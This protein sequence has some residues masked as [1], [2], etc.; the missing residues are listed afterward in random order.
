VAREDA[1][2]ARLHVRI[3]QS[4]LPSARLADIV[5]ATAQPALARLENHVAQARRH[6]SAH[7]AGALVPLRALLQAVAPDLA[8]LE[9]LAS[10]PGTAHLYGDQVRLVADTVL[11]GLVACQRVTGDDLGCLPLLFH[12]L[13]I[14]SAPELAQRTAQAF[15]VMLENALVAARISAGEPIP[16]DHVLTLR[17]ITRSISAGLGSLGL[18]NAATV[19]TQA[20]LAGWLEKLAE[21]ALVLS[22]SN[23]GWALHTLGHAL[24]LPIDAANREAL[25]RIQAEWLF[26]APAPSLQPFV[27]IAGLNNLRID[28]SGVTLNNKLLRTAD[29][30]GIRHQMAGFSGE[31]PQTIGWCS[32]DEG[33]E[34]DEAWFAALKGMMNPATAARNILAALHAFL[35]P[36]LLAR[37]IQAVR[38]GGVITMGESRLSAEGLALTEGGRLLPFAR[39][40]LAYA[41]ERVSISSADHPSLTVD[42]DPLLN[43][44]V[45]LLPHFIAAFTPRLP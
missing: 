27:L 35:V 33:F 36:S 23:L 38:G 32:S 24:D 4:H 17:L 12:L 19:A 18:T 15:G 37:T 43:W 5:E 6:A 22:P 44:N 3:A 1:Q 20:R 7:P 10:A 2:T 28:A 40:R 29:F 34:L 26:T 14:A 13:D 42:L 8:L 41:P 45:V 39:L 21:E 11:D 16:P 9:I 31:I 30:I 25:V